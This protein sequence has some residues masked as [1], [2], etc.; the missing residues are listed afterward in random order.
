MIVEQAIDSR[1]VI[2][3]RA[4][5]AEGVEIGPWSVIGADVVI[6]EGTWVGP[7]AVIKG[8]TRMGRNNKVYQFS[9]IGEDPQD[10][11]YNGEKTEL[12]IGDDNIFRE[13]TTISRGTAQGGRLTHIGNDNLFMAYVHIAHDCIIG[14]HTIFS[15]NASLAGHVTV[16]DYATFG[17]FSAVHQFCRIGA[18][19]FLSRAMVGKDVLPYLM[20]SGPE[21]AVC[22]LNSVGLKR[23]GFTSE[24]LSWLKRAYKVIFRQGLKIPQALVELEKMVPECAHIQAFIDALQENPRGIVR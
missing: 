1:A 4:V 2:H 14:N 24:T 17:G 3:P 13:C 5:I 12:I 15:N 6:G 16:D 22:G 18:H 7:H 20:I 8:P 11:K 10:K 19:A 21:A 23:R 9:S